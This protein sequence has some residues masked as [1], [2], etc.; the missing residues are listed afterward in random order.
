M[1]ERSYVPKNIEPIGRSIF[2]GKEGIQKM[3]E[4]KVRSLCAKSALR[5]PESQTSLQ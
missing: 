3:R 1:T 4:L 5:N 2:A